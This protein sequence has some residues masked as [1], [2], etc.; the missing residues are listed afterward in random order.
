MAA[1]GPGA[2]H[3]FLTAS[4]EACGGLPWPAPYLREGARRGGDGT[5]CTVLLTAH[6]PPDLSAADA[7]PASV[8]AVGTARTYRALS[9]AGVPDAVILLH[10]SGAGSAA[11]LNSARSWESPLGHVEPA[12]DIYEILSGI[13]DRSNPEAGVPTR[14][15]PWLW[16]IAAQYDCERR[17]NL[18]IPQLAAVAV[19]PALTADAAGTAQLTQAICTAV[20]SVAPARR[21]AI[22]ASVEAADGDPCGSVAMLALRCAQAIAGGT[23]M[24]RS[25][26]GGEPTGPWICCTTS[27]SPCPEP[28][29]ADVHRALTT[30]SLLY[31]Y[32]EGS[33]WGAP[34]RWAESHGPCSCEDP[35]A[36]W[37]GA[38]EFHDA[39]VRFADD[40]LHA[41]WTPALSAVS[42]ENGESAPPPRGV[43]V[44]C[45]GAG[46]SAGPCGAF[47]P[48]CVFS[49]LAQSL[50][51][52]GVST[53][54]LVYPRWSAGK[55]SV[56]GA[57]QP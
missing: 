11:R 51:E 6:T 36:S 16:F 7:D 53:L 33:G 57:S 28:A 21:V 54:Q 56:A 12:A 46:A 27:A 18:V 42:A 24:P 17:E 20:R 30:T 3:D 1:V 14:H 45:P 49:R 8:A 43:L 47:G 25:L 2:A 48:Y 31:R 26:C 55:P 52:N 34:L 50:R 19:D 13:V 4:F 32:T 39:A 15:A 29:P 5:A 38:G 44:T 22:I 35:A 10:S 41:I 37:G 9:V 23:P 40:E